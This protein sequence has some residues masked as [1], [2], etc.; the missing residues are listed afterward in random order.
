MLVGAAGELDLP[1]TGSACCQFQKLSAMLGR[2]ALADYC[3]AQVSTRPAWAGMVCPH[4]AQSQQAAWQHTPAQAPHR[5]QALTPC[6]HLPKP[7]FDQRGAA[8]ELGDLRQRS[9]LAALPACL[10]LLLLGLADGMC[11]GVS[12]VAHQMQRPCGRVGGGIL[13]LPD[14]AQEPVN[15]R[16]SSTCTIRQSGDLAVVFSLLAARKPPVAAIAVPASPGQA[17]HCSKLCP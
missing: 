11:H 5:W 14:G 8:R 16:Q 10:V 13:R 4:A 17:S 15:G 2:T 3:L 9:G 1:P 12:H 7:C 6:S